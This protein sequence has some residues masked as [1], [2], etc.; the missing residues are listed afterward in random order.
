MVVNE[1]FTIQDAFRFDG[2]RSDDKGGR[3]RA[4]E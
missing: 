2:F 1:W 4:E 3:L